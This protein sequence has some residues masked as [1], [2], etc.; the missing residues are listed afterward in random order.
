MEIENYILRIE[1]HTHHHRDDWGVESDS[2]TCLDAD[3]KGLQEGD[4]VKP[5]EYRGEGVTRCSDPQ[6]YLECQKIEDTSLT[7]RF[8]FLE[9]YHG[10]EITVGPDQP[11]LAG[12]STDRSSSHYT[13]S[14][15]PKEQ[16][17]PQKGFI[18]YL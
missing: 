6:T 11:A 7:F 10:T 2:Y 16:Y 5:T 4:T 1:R 3:L 17:A 15:V 12:G 18:N 8:F 9:N 14:L 13:L